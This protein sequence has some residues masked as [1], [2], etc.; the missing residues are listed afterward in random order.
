MH[1]CFN[2]IDLQTKNLSQYTGPLKTQKLQRYCRSGA[3]NSLHLRGK[4]MYWIPVCRPFNSLS[5]CIILPLKKIHSPHCL[6]TKHRFVNI[7]ILVDILSSRGRH[8]NTPCFCTITA[9]LT[10]L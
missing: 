4:Y 3:S 7:Q 6:N 1:Y 5:G 10:E 9:K 2:L 8:I